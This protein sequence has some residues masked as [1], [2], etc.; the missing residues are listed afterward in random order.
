MKHYHISNSMIEKWHTIRQK[1]SH[2]EK[3]KLYAQAVEVKVKLNRRKRTVF[4]KTDDHYDRGYTLIYVYHPSKH[5]T[6]N[7]C[8]FNVGPTSNVAL[9]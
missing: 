1:S 2:A 9:K 6:I 7:Q 5:V 4:N 8:C 3:K